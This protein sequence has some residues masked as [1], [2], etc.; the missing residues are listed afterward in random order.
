MTDVWVC[1][2]CHSINR[3]RNATC[4]KCGARQDTS[5]T[6]QLADLRTERA[7]IQR[8]AK[9]YRS[10]LLFAIIAGVFILMVAG[11]GVLVLNESVAAYRVLRDQIP[12]I[13][14]GSV[15]QRELAATLAPTVVPQ[16]VQNVIAL[17]AL[18]SFAVWLS[19][20]VANIPALGGGTPSVSSTRAFFAPFIPIYNL[21]KVPPIMQDA[22]YRTDPK[23]GGFFMIAVA[24]I[25]LVGS[26][27]VSFFAGWWLNLRVLSIAAN[28][29]SVG[30]AI[31]ELVAAFDMG[32]IVDIITSLMISIGSVILV[33]VMLRIERRARARDREI[34]RGA[35]AMVAAH[36]AELEADLERQR[37]PGS[38]PYATPVVAAPFVAAPVVAAPATAG[39]GAA[40][41][42]GASDQVPAPGF[43]AE[44][45]PRLSL[46]VTGQSIAASLDA[47]AE[48][49]ATIDDLR[50]AA[51]ALAQRGGSATVLVSH[52][53]VVGAGVADQIVTVLRGAGVPTTLA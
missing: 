29:T 8:G 10:S 5:A 31:D 37:S 20:V 28:A 18:T 17:L 33:L 47:D 40:T 11:L 34:R 36:Q 32:M 25:G 14:G 52:G 15:S 23:A 3:Q 46:V 30:Q 4:Y 12:G 38:S 45:G 27:I 7:I 21:V 19:R 2:T 51:P 26:V 53:D 39:A 1:A 6:G 48:E 22:L 43:G 16:L 13:V 50:M 35:A 9:R 24:W 41:V 42:V 44:P 49:A